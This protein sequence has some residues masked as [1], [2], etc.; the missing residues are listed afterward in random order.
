LHYLSVMG[1]RI[2]LRAWLLYLRRCALQG[3]RLGPGSTFTI[4]T[5]KPGAA[6]A[7]FIMGCL[8]RC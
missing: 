3:E 2:V 7:L 8:C 4:I 6:L 1:S 5:G